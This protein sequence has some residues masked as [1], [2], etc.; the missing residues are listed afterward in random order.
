MLQLAFAVLAAAA[1]FGAG[2]AVRYLHLR[3]PSA[4][5]LPQAL[6]LA[7]GSL[8]VAGLILLIAVLRRG[9]PSTDNGTVGF[10]LIAAGFFSLALVLGLLIAALAWRGRRP[11]GL[12][13][14]THASVAI[15]G[16]VVLAALVA[17]G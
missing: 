6:P 14:G 13:V 9:L 15:A 8:G 10:G 5:R 12:V 17:L 16:V 7:H 1:L 3:G 2:L 4:P 11:G